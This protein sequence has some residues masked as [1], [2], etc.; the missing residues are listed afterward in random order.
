M[1]DTLKEGRGNLKE[2]IDLETS[3]KFV[4]MLRLYVTR[5]GLD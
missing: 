5:L 3:G 1:I 2:N 4:L